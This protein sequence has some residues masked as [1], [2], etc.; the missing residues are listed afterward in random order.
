[1]HHLPP[2]EVVQGEE[3]LLDNHADIR[4]VELLISLQGFQEGPIRLVL[5][6]HIDVILVLEKVKEAD[7]THALF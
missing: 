2:F 6:D 1:V 3:H 5:Q 7:D 4:L